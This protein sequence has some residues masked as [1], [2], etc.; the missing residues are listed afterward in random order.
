MYYIHADH[1]GS[2][3]A[4][5][6]PSDNK[7]VWRW[8]NVDPFGN[9]PPNEN[10]SGLGNFEFNLRFPGMYSDK[11]TGTFYNYF[12][13]YDPVTG[14]HPQSDPIGLR[15]GTNTYAYVGS[16][17]LKYIDPFGLAR[18]TVDAAIEGAAKRGDVNELR[19]LL[20]AAGSNEERA[21]AEAA[22][23]RLTSKAED[24]IARECKGSVNREFPDQ[25]R[26]KT[27]EEIMKLKKEGDDAAIKAWKLL[28]DNR[29]KK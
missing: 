15:G 3:R 1:L 9:N 27:L 26:R 19:A 7:V 22:I 25:M 18:T 6:R 20:E 8:D 5:T 12:R 21:A 11:E 10:P 14:R 13:D 29:F 17:P 23:K 28:T 24:V 4:I 16:D 2:P